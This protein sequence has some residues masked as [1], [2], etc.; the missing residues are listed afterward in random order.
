M[1]KLSLAIPFLLLIV[2]RDKHANVLKWHEYE[3]GLA[4]KSKIIVMI[5]EMKKVAFLI[6]HRIKKIKILLR[7][8]FEQGLG[9]IL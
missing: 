6:F 1:T 3:C 2:E 4:L 8:D 9:I 7:T 5:V